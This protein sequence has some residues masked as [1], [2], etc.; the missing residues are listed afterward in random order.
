MPVFLVNDEYLMN[1][2][3]GALRK[4]PIMP[5]VSL[6]HLLVTSSSKLG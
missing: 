4:R 1:R 5:S 3:L 2:K 6:A